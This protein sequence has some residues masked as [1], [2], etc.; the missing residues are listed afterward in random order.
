[1]D[2]KMTCKL[3]SASV[4]AQTWTLGIV[5]LSCLSHIHATTTSVILHNAVSV[6]VGSVSS[7]NCSVTGSGPDPQSVVWEIKDTSGTTISN[8][9]LFTTQLFDTANSAD[10][11]VISQATFTVV[12][13][14][15][16]KRLFCTVNDQGTSSTMSIY[17]VITATNQAN[18]GQTC[19]AAIS[20]SPANSR[21]SNNICV[22]STGY[23]V[24]G[25]TCNQIQL[26]DSCASS[27]C[28][29]AN[30]ICNS[31]SICACNTNYYASSGSCILKKQLGSSCPVGNSQ[32]CA[33]SDSQCSSFQ[34]YVCE[35]QNG[36]VQSGSTCVLSQVS[37]GQACVNP[38]RQC[39]I[40]HSNCNGFV[41]VCDYQYEQSNNICIL[42]PA[43][44]GESCTNPSRTCSVSDSA[45]TFG[46]CQCSNGFVS[47][48]ST[49]ITST[50]G[51]GDSCSNPSRSCTVLNTVCDQFSGYTCQCTGNYVQFGNQCIANYAT[52][53]QSC[54]NP[55]RTCSTTNTICG[56]GSGICVCSSGYFQSGSTCYLSNVGLGDQCSN[57][58][59]T[60]LTT[61]SQCGSN[62][63]CE[64]AS[65]Y[66]QSGSLCYES[67]VGLNQACTNPSRTCS[68]T[69]SICGSSGL[70]VCG[71]GY[72]QSGSSCITSTA[73]LGESCVNPSRT[74]VTSNSA[75]GSSGICTCSTGYVTFNSACFS[76]T[77]NLGDSCVNPTLTCSVPNSS[78]GV[79]GTCTCSQ[80]YTQSGSTCVSNSAG[81]GESCTSPTR[82]CVDANTEC[83]ATNGTC[84]CESGYVSNS[85]TCI[86]E[87]VNLGDSCVNPSRTCIVSNSQCSQG[88]CSCRGGYVASGN[89]CILPVAGQAC[90]SSVGC[91][92]TGSS[93]NPSC[94]NNI[95][96][97]PNNYY[98]FNAECK[99]KASNG[100]TCFSQ[101]SN[102]CQDIHAS[103]TGTC[104]CNTGYALQGSTC[105]QTTTTTSCPANTQNPFTVN[106][107]SN[108]PSTYVGATC[109]EVNLHES[110]QMVCEDAKGQPLSAAGWYHMPSFTAVSISTGGF[111][112][113]DISNT[114]LTVSNALSN[115]TGDYMCRLCYSSSRCTNSTTVQLRVLGT[116]I[117]SSTLSVSPSGTITKGSTVTLTCSTSPTG[118]ASTY[119]FYK[120]STVIQ[121]TT[122]STFQIQNVQTTH[123]GSYRCNAS[124]TYNSQVSSSVAINVQYSPEFT[125]SSGT[126]TQTVTH[127]FD[128]G[129]LVITCSGFSANPAISAYTFYN[130]A[131]SQLASSASASYT[132]NSTQGYQIYYCRATNSLG[133][134]NEQYIDVQEP[135]TEP[136]VGASTENTGLGTGTIAAIVLGIIFL[137]LLIIIIIVCCC[138][139]GWC[140]KKEKVEPEIHI[141]SQPPVKPYIP[142]TIVSATPSVRTTKEV[143]VM[144]NGY[145]DARATRIRPIC[146]STEEYEPYVASPRYY[147]KPATSTGP[148]ISMFDDSYEQPRAHQLPALDTQY[149]YS[150]DHKP[151]HKKKRRKH[152]RSHREPSPRR[153][154][155]A[156]VT[157]PSDE[158]LVVVPGKQN[159]MEADA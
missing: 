143:G 136:G 99:T 45:C 33:P 98:T 151:R 100:Q 57:P 94:V 75:C 101:V 141:V 55:S 106:G 1:M 67:S 152:R 129:D 8:A 120:D 7:Y 159:Y 3:R 23:T 147:L 62:G 103:C 29:V 74:C 110:T 11:S 139:Y 6:Q 41:C 145:T 126:S 14:H 127:N 36:Y 102:S 84:D 97:C 43:G 80:G 48:G 4:L 144:M 158:D 92:A 104:T 142:R 49:C 34:P 154:V 130:E 9:G 19:S 148:I 10:G 78:C 70:C 107:A 68:V 90:V 26:G 42:S 96:E 119:I 125:L 87:S 112:N 44:L 56:Q 86:S 51:L 59:R 85:V 58:T 83:N 66:F 47:S 52:I 39:Y 146:V 122:Q 61:N 21:C 137:L 22:C 131:G 28:P 109:Y 149:L 89:S 132:V 128:D 24:N 16:G 140:R 15:L 73:S 38:V 2:Y 72:V 40:V 123:I 95:C 153:D 25:N 157:P 135:G 63:F 53:G 32:A 124:N 46:T 60:C 134:S 27:S 88:V 37:L 118:V 121:S 31:Q 155:Y 79:S 65:G 105:T 82:T 138:S 114:D 17:T 111:I 76:S 116:E 113:G 30:S 117:Q 150:D 156:E 91:G 5:F 71:S 13:S 93:V 81:L 18:L 12:Q 20:C 77:V 69:N 108:F 50:A 35:C 115:Y 54:I 133:T 64:C